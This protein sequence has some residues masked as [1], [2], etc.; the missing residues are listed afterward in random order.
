MATNHEIFVVFVDDPTASPKTLAAKRVAADK[1]DLLTDGRDVIQIRF[2]KWNGTQFFEDTYSGWPCFKIAR[3]KGP[4]EGAVI[5]RCRPKN[6]GTPAEARDVSYVDTDN[7]GATQRTWPVALE[8][9]AM[10][11]SG[12]RLIS[13]DNDASDWQ[14]LHDTAAALDADDTPLTTA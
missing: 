9:A 11:G 13:Y 2:R 1:C 5:T 3:H 12:T 8:Q 14:S 10:G 6:G 7:P 4:E